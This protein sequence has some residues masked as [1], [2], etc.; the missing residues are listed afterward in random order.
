MLLVSVV[1]FELGN[2]YFALRRPDLIFFWFQKISQNSKPA[3]SK[4][5]E[6]LSKWLFNFILKTKHFVPNYLTQSFIVNE[7]L[8]MSGSCTRFPRKIFFPSYSASRE[9]F[10]PLSIQYIMVRAASLGRCRYPEM[11]FGVI[12]DSR[13]KAFHYMVCHGLVAGLCNV[14]AVE[15][16]WSNRGLHR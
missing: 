11:G 12:S 4:Y 15:G 10:R 9:I 13:P 7:Y 8:F 5:P 3:T 16:H 6:F 1:W 14:L 2:I